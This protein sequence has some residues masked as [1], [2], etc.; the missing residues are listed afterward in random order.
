MWPCTAHQVRYLL[1]VLIGAPLY[2]RKHLWRPWVHPS[3][4]SI[5][6]SFYEFYR[7]S[8][9]DLHHYRRCTRGH[10]IRTVL[11]DKVMSPITD[12]KDVPSCLHGTYLKRLE[13]IKELGLVSYWRN[14]VQVRRTRTTACPSVAHRYL[15]CRYLGPTHTHFCSTSCLQARQ[16]CLPTVRWSLKSML[17]RPCPEAFAFTG[18]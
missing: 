3:L 11:V 12:A 8:F 18:M 14:H 10:T 7:F 2:A 17:P 16:N 13:Q 1:F 6:H 9:H 5:F 4:S 15:Y